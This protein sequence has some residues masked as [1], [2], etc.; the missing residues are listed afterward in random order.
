MANRRQRPS[1]W[2]EALTERDLEYPAQ[3]EARRKRVFNDWTKGLADRPPPTTPQLLWIC[4]DL[5]RNPHRIQ[6]PEAPSIFLILQRWFART[7]APKKDY[8]PKQI[9]DLV[10]W[11]IDRE[12]VRPGEAYLRVQ[13]AFPA[14][15]VQ[16]VRQAH[17][18]FGKSRR[19]NSQ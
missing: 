16:A 2:F 13:K 1:T 6:G 17:L 10:N 3:L 5:L 4:K 18:R 19:D 7:P 12:N 9:A 11:V 8:T 15:T 14:I